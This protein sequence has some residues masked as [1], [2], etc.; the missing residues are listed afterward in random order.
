MSSLFLHALI[1]FQKPLDKFRSP[2]YNYIENRCIGLRGI[3]VKEHLSKERGLAEGAC[4]VLQ[5]GLFFRYFLKG[6]YHEN[7]KGTN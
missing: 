7:W 5:R 2:C 4:E 6:A 1:F 3:K